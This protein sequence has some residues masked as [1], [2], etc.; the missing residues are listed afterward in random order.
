MQP[1]ASYVLYIYMYRFS[2][3]TYAHTHTYNMCIQCQ[4]IFVYE[5]WIWNWNWETS[6]NFPFLAQCHSF[7]SSQFSFCCDFVV[8]FSLWIS[9]FDLNRLV[10]LIQLFNNPLI[11]YFALIFFMSLFDIFSLSLLLLQLNEKKPL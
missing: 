5:T 2:M 4:Q 8:F 3:Y 9:E 1:H 10:A 7:Y 6:K 11:K